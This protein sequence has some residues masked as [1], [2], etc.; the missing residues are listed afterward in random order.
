MFGELLSSAIKISTLPVD[1]V[2]IGMDIATGGDGS[3]QS[4]N[5]CDSPLSMLEQARDALADAAEDID[6]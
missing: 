1:A 6:D 4:R 3:K 2:N 5:G